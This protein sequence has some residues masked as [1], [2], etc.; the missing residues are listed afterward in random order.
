M[1]GTQK[2]KRKRVDYAKLNISGFDIP[3]PSNIQN[4][5]SHSDSRRTGKIQ[6]ESMSK[7]KIDNYKKVDCKKN[8][9]KY[10]LS[11]E[12]E[13]L[14]KTC[15]RREYLAEPQTKTKNLHEKK[16]TKKMKIVI[17][18]SSHEQ[19]DSSFTKENTNQK[20]PNEISC[21]EIKQAI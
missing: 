20:I 18:C 12:L 10:S 17:T 21:K 15:N 5:E 7:P 8:P 19:K 1:G 16:L 3:S 13:L 14:K 6:S 2:C 11:Q 4:E 9:K